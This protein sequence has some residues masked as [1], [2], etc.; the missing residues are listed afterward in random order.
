MLFNDMEQ[1]TKVN[2]FLKVFV[3]FFHAATRNQGCVI[4]QLQQLKLNTVY[5]NSI[6]AGHVQLNHGAKGSMIAYSQHL[7][8]DI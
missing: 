7:V 6:L 1:A 3:Q 8:H 4:S 2:W 5:S